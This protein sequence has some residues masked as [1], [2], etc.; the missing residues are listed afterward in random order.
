MRLGSTYTVDQLRVLRH[1]LDHGTHSTNELP[2]SPVDTGTMP[3]LPLHQRRTRG[4]LKQVVTLGL[5]TFFVGIIAWGL[6][7]GQGGYSAPKPKKTLHWKAPSHGPPH[8]SSP[9]AAAAA[10]T[11]ATALVSAAPTL[12]TP[13]L[14]SLESAANFTVPAPARV[15]PVPTSL[16]SQVLPSLAASTS[17]SAEVAAAALATERGGPRALRGAPVAA[18][19]ALDLS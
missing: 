14:L 3:V 7:H 2:P 16:S 9:T 17:P 8:M 5:L 13:L 12:P 15:A 11:A 1:V 6:L 10:T 18:S 4:W 19:D